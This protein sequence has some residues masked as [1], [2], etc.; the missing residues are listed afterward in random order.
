M[1]GDAADQLPHRS[2]ALRRVQLAVKIFR[3]DYVCSSLRPGLR[4][5][6]TLPDGKSSGLYHCR[7]VRC[8]FPI[9]LCRTGEIVP[10]VNIRRNSR[11]RLEPI[12]CS[13]ASLLL[14]AIRAS[15]MLPPRRHEKVEPCLGLGKP[16]EGLYLFYPSTS[17]SSMATKPK[18]GIR[19]ATP[20]IKPQPIAVSGWGWFPAI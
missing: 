2:F 5:F 20:R 12:C 16:R 4:Y 7:S 17:P 10:S 6:Y 15:A 1:F 8:A 9:R 13:E 3:R 18:L 14:S 19:S 11:P